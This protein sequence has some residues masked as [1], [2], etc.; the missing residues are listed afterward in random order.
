MSSTLFVTRRGFGNGDLQ[1][2]RMIIDLFLILNHLKNVQHYTAV[3]RIFPILSG[4]IPLSVIQFSSVMND[5]VDLNI[6][7]LPAPGCNPPSL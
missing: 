6:D 5:N 4:L 3:C 1:R 7:H 2:S